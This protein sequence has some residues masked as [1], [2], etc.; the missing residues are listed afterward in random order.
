LNFDDSRLR[1]L[2][3]LGDFGLVIDR[4]LNNPQV[5]ELEIRTLRF[6]RVL[7]EKPDP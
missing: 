5:I 1:K 6:F 2:E 3:L 4:G 7:L